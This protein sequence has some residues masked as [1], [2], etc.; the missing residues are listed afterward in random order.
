MRPYIF[1]KKKFQKTGLKWQ[2]DGENVQL[3]ECELR[4]Q[5][6]YD[7]LENVSFYNLSFEYDFAEKDD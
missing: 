7:N 5:I 3:R 1:S 6:V 4:Y 2:Q